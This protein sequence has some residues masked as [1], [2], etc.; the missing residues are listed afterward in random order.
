MG[1]SKG[2]RKMCPSTLPDLGY[3][4][5]RGE[6][7]GSGCEPVPKTSTASPACVSSVGG[8]EIDPAP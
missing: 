6:L 1:G 3:L 4:L 7:A 2:T 5:S 8:A